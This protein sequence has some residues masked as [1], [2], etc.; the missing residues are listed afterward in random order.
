MSL[1]YIGE[2]YNILFC[3]Y[4]D[5][6]NLHMI[7]WELLYNKVCTNEEIWDHLHHIVPRHHRTGDDR[8]VRLSIRTHILAH[9]IRYRWL[10]YKSDRMAVQVMTR[11]PLPIIEGEID[12]PIRN[13]KKLK[14][15]FDYTKMEKYYESLGM[16]EFFHSTWG[17]K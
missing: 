11:K 16:I 1:L 4:I 6:Y 7:D 9:Y 8:V 2:R 12:S 17:E 15:K 10:K 3:L 13:R 14:G 5:K